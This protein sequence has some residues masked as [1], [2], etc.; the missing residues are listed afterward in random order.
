MSFANWAVF[1][2]DLAVKLIINFVMAP[3][4]IAK[5]VLRR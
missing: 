5:K 3:K 2:I 4:K 1:L